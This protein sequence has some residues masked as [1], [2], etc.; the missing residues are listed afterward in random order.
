MASEHAHVLVVAALVRACGHAALFAH[1]PG[2]R[3]ASGTGN[4]CCISV[5]K[6][7]VIEGL[8]GLLIG[9]GLISSQTMLGS[10]RRS[11]LMFSLS[12]LPVCW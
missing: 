2:A 11:F 3:E 5:A 12:C 10:T 4:V 9:R 6:P 8:P 7:V 1:V